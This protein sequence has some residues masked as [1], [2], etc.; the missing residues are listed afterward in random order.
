MLLKFFPDRDFAA[1]DITRYNR[2]IEA[3]FSGIR[4]FLL[5][6][7][8]HTERTDGFWRHCRAI[9]LTDS[10]REKIALFQSHGR[11]LRETP[12]LF[13]TL[14]WLAVMVGQGIIP[15]QYDPLVDGL[16]ARK[17][18][19]RLEELR[20]SVRDCVAAMPLHGDFIQS[21]CSRGEAS[22]ALSM[23]PSV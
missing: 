5:L 1:A 20:A 21:D 13:S 9:P 6:H 17:I 22:A 19:A 15:R 11:I 7:Y 4:D 23:H 3:E 18:H 14:S 12:E 10:L 8:T 16:D 2:A